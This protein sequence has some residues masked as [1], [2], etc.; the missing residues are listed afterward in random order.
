MSES[1][2]E[3]TIDDQQSVDSLCETIWEGNDYVPTVFPR[4]V[5]TQDSHTLGLF[6]DNELIAIGNIEKTEGTT[7]ALVQGLR[8]KDTHREKGYAT[9][10]T[11][12]LSEL[13]KEKGM[14]TLWYA[15]SSRNNVSI[16][17]ALKTGFTQVATTG[18]FRLYNPFP[19]HAKP[20]QSIVPLQV[21]PERLF[22]L[23]EINPDIVKDDKFPLAW[24]FDFKT[25]EGLTRLT[26]R[27]INKVVIDEVG[28][29]QAVYCVTE[30]E[31]KEEKT[32]AYT[33]FATDRAIFVDIMSRMIDESETAG[34]DR[35]VFFLGPNT[36]EWA[37]DLGYVTE[38]FTGRRFL[39]YEKKL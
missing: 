12:A 6:E 10:V 31:R 11:N 7:I 35:A 16:S 32:S 20:S 30:R 24:Q 17:V 15:T 3:L 23:L 25:I 21:N 26:S 39:L 29:P 13:A 34:V 19:D 33:V 36:T 27:A 18:Y 1:L 9:K 38:E 4:W 37:Q 8:V 5:S 28:N 2:R 14:T 22:E